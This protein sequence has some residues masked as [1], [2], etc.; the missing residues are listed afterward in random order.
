MG[1]STDAGYVTVRLGAV[2]PNLEAY[3]QVEP[4]SALPVSAAEAEVITGL[5]VL[6]GMHVRAGQE[7]A[8]L[9]GP[10]ITALLS[11]SRADVRSAQAQ[12]SASQRSLAIQRQ[13]LASHL[14]TRQAVQQAE[15]AAPVMF[16]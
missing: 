9:N 11:Q 5:K 4:I 7:L 2:T 12:L 10:E 13:Q 3:G 16:Q 1:Q 14:S 6:P 15:S 8:R